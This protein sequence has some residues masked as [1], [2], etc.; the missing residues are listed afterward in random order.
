MTSF[1]A[2]LLATTLITASSSSAVFADES[3]G[4]HPAVIVARTWAQRP[5]DPNTFIVAHPARLTVLSEAPTESA[6]S[7]VATAAAK[8]AAQKQR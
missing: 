4:E 7:K 1:S 6:L 5:I 8:P 3:L 2:R